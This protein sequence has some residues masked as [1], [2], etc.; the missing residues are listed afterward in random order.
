MAPQP[1]GRAPQRLVLRRQRSQA[2]TLAAPEG[3]W[4]DG[5]AGLGWGEGGGG[6]VADGVDDLDGD[7]VGHVVGQGQAR[8]LGHC[9]RSTDRL[10]DSIENAYAFSHRRQ[11]LDSS[12]NIR[13]SQGI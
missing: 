7:F 13:R 2:Q 3:F 5:W 12:V 8:P 4:G 9:R 1:S 11:K 6:A 10:G